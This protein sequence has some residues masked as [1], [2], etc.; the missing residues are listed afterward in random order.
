MPA[1][2]A[3]SYHPNSQLH[4]WQLTTTTTPHKHNT[5]A[6]GTIERNMGVVGVLVRPPV[7][8]FILYSDPRLCRHHNKEVVPSFDS[9]RRGLALLVLAFRHNTTRGWPL[10]GSFRHDTRRWDVGPDKKQGVERVGVPCMPTFIF[11]FISTDYLT[12]NPT[13]DEEGFSSLISVWRNGGFGFSRSP[14][15]FPSTQHHK[16]GL[17]LLINPFCHRKIRGAVIKPGSESEW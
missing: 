5:T 1:G 4:H 8:S 3:A 15:T 10:V 12:K 6:R 9:P 14:R 17:L 13:R 16:E 11:P 7:F 2:I